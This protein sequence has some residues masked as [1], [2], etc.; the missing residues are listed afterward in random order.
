MFREHAGKLNKEGLILDWGKQ[1]DGIL[2]IKNRRV[3]S[4]GIR[5]KVYREGGDKK[6][7]SI[8]WLQK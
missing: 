4:N 7:A 5:I 8:I 6:G 1:K 3:N 2:G